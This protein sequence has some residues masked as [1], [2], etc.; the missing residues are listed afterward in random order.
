MAPIAWASTRRWRCVVRNDAAVAVHVQQVSQRHTVHDL[1][2]GQ[3][4]LVV[5]RGAAMNGGLCRVRDRSD[6]RVGQSAHTTPA[7]HHYSWYDRNV[8][9]T[10]RGPTVLGSMMGSICSCSR[11]HMCTQ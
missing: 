10:D 4:Q 7:S 5:Q 2:D 6:H 1:I 8:Q 11:H 3:L 9:G